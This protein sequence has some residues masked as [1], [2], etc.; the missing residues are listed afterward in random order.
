MSDDDLLRRE[1]EVHRKNRVRW[2]EL[3]EARE[4]RMRK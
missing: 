3:N 2:L 4:R 1:L